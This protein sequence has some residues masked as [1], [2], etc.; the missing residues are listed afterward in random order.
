MKSEGHTQ[1]N[2]PGID[3]AARCSGVGRSDTLKSW[4]KGEGLE[5]RVLHCA[6][7]HCRRPIR[8]GVA[9]HAAPLALL[10][11]WRGVLGYCFVPPSQPLRVER[12]GWF[13][14]VR[15]YL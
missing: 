7:L 13:V 11:R 2:A 1:G 4:L 9:L 14:D 15:K 3:M 5:G 8:C 12:L 10:G 6:R